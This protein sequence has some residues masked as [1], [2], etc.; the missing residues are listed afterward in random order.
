MSAKGTFY[1]LC[2]YVIFFNAFFVKLESLAMPTSTTSP[3]PATKSWTR[4]QIDAMSEVIGKAVA[5]LIRK[6]MWAFEGSDTA[7]FEVQ[8][9]LKFEQNAIC[10]SRTL[11]FKKNLDGAE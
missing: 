4:S 7:A 6:M 2:F 5:E 3:E 1:K 10:G 8:S 9:R 11:V